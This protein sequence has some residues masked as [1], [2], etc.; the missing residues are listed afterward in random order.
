[1]PRVALEINQAW[2]LRNSF[3]IKS[4]LWAQR[5][6]PDKGRWRAS[7]LAV[8]EGGF[9]VAKL[10]ESFQATVDCSLGPAGSPNNVCR[11]LAYQ[12]MVTAQEI[13]V[14]SFKWCY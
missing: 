8:G 3:Q 1:M 6:S 11:R 14:C 9:H 5:H 2:R 12:R 13:L 7:S 4:V 10:R